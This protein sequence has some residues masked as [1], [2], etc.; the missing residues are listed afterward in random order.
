ML[1][2][3]LASLRHSESR[4]ILF[5]DR[6]VTTWN[7]PSKLWHSLIGLKLEAPNEGVS[8]VGNSPLTRRAAVRRISNRPFSTRRLSGFPTQRSELRPY[9]AQDITKSAND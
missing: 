2:C 1:I 4:W 7:L 9:R 3:L 6:R 8:F 5:D